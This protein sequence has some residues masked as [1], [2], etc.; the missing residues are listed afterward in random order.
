MVSYPTSSFSVNRII[1]KIILRF[2]LAIK[3]NSLTV[4]FIL[5]GIA[6]SAQQR[7]Y[8]NVSATGTN[9][10]TSWANAFTTINAAYTKVSTGD[11]LWI[12]GGTY[13]ATTD[14]DRLKSMYFKDGVKVYGGFT[15]NETSLAQRDWVNNQT[16]LSGD[17]GIPGDNVDNTYHILLVSGQIA[18]TELDGLIITGGNCRN[19]VSVPIGSPG[20]DANSGKGAG[21]VA[22][23]K[24]SIVF[25]NCVI[26]NNTSKNGG[27]FGGTKSESSFYN[28]VFRNNN[29]FDNGGAFYN[30]LSGNVKFLDCDFI[31]NTARR[32]AAIDHASNVVAGERALTTITDCNF[33][34]NTSIE[35]GGAVRFSEG[36]I[37]GSFFE[38]NKANMGGALSTNSNATPS[39]TRFI[40]NCKFNKNKADGMGGAIHSSYSMNISNSTFYRN[41]AGGSGGA[42]GHN[43]NSNFTIHAFRMYNCTVINNVCGNIGSGLY[44]GSTVDYAFDISIV[45]SIVWDND[46]KG[47]PVKTSYTS[48]ITPNGARYNKDVVRVNYCL[49]NSEYAS[50][51]PTTNTNIEANPALDTTSVSYWQLFEGSAAINAGITDTTGLQLGNNDIELNNRMQN[52]RIDIGASEYQGSFI[53]AT[54]IAIRS[55]DDQLSVGL[56]DTLSLYADFTPA[57]ATNRGVKWKIVD[58]FVYGKIDSEGRLSSQDQTTPGVVRVQAVS[59]Y[60]ATILDE[61]EFTF[62][63]PVATIALYT[64]GDITQI[65]EDETLQILASILPSNATDKTLLWEV[66]QGAAIASVSDQGVLTPTGPGAVTVKVTA[67][68]GSGASATYQLLVTEVQVTVSEIV[69][70]TEGNITEITTGQSLQLMATV[71]PEHATNKT[72]S[73]EIQQG[74]ACAE[75][76]SN[77]LLTVS[78]E[79]QVIVKT[80]ATDGSGIVA[81]YEVTVGSV[82]TGLPQSNEKA[83][84]VY[85]NPTEGKVSIDVTQL[86]GAPGFDIEVLDSTGKSMVNIHTLDNTFDFQFSPSSG[87]YILR[88]S[89]GIHKLHEK[90]I[91]R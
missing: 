10:G 3:R 81:Q 4:I 25:R 15:G 33:V 86:P 5:S 46:A 28:C 19:Q 51:N 72:L 36:V 11:T 12:A 18:G 1:L 7:Y 42:I 77:G 47:R 39:G 50:G 24:E 35:Q 2:F 85:P 56:Q 82:V 90:I 31:E 53:S 34:K 91:V 68:D 20:F 40:K 89:K 14:N 65:R 84:T 75:I 32:G 58:G 80:S 67:R 70:S 41:E 71:L 22:S 69:L 76:S 44:A 87:I 30:A 60:D 37:K 21:I 73:W 9:T 17:I 6:A 63:L 66:I 38:Q 83:I 26:S 16:I 29:A 52:G 59:V 79:G 64:T 74:S 45:N 88:I 61:K 57:N 23:S 55:E 13:L 8:I 48:Q 43:S 54:G 62:Y 27:G 78:C 49:T